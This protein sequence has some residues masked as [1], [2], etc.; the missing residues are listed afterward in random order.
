[1]NNK[2]N[3][4]V[5]IEKLRCTKEGKISK[6][7]H[8]S[9]FG[10]RM[11]NNFITT[12][13][14]EA[15][16]EIRTPICNN[17]EE[18][19]LKLE[20]I[21]N[22]VIDE[23]HKNDELLWPYSMPCIL[24]K[25]EEF[26]FG[27][28]GEYKEETKYEMDLYEKY[29]HKMH[30]M[31]G[32]H[33][34]FSL[35][36]NFFNYIKSKN[37]NLPKITDEAYLKIMRQFMEK[38]WML[39]YFFGA[40]PMQCEDDIESAISIR[41]SYKHGFKNRKLIDIDFNSRINYAKSIQKNIDAGNLLSA[42]EL[43][44]PIRAKSEN[45][46]N[47]IQDLLESEINHIEIRLCDIN[48]FDKCGI[49]KKDLEFSVAFLFYCLLSEEKK[50]LSYREVAENGITEEERMILL[51]ELNKIMKINNELELGCS[52]GIEEKIDMCKKGLTSAKQVKNMAEKKGLKEGLLE[53]A[54]EHSKDGYNNRYI[55]KNYPNLE[56]ST[57]V[58]LKSAITQGIDFNILNENK[59]F[60]ELIN[61]NHKEYIVQAT[62]TNRDSY[63]FPFITDDKY[64]AKN[65][66]KGNGLEVPESIMINNEMEEAEKEKLISRF[67]NKKCVVKPRTTNCGTG[68]TVFSE[69]ATKEQLYEAIKYAT[70]FEDD[71]LVEEYVEG[72]EYRFTVIDGK[73]ES[74]IWRRNA[75]ILGNGINTIYELIEMKNKEDW[76]LLL[77]HPIII[78]KP[79]E[80][81]IKQQGY[82][83]EYIP[84]KDE[85]IFLREN[86]NCST[87]GESVAMTEIMPEKFKKIAEQTAKL[88]NAKIC[89]VDI[90]IDNLQKDEYKII[91]INDN[92]GLSSSQWPYEGA[93]RKVGL[94]I[95]EFLSLCN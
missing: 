31:S 23:I 91:E 33:I 88:F 52:D 93:G 30:C 53:L 18:C 64:F 82:T 8:P 57:V 13:F 38:A 61:H 51:D 42:R 77:R 85:R 29:G 83:F 59:N 79:V 20:E 26:V 65:V 6:T 54:E 46:N 75:S 89:G 92:P 58:V 21:T 4:G 70:K 71:I 41:N 72:K 19:Y 60:I 17:I 34:N 7:R 63:I 5:E 32:V 45:K 39:I 44:I 12:D 43:Y 50:G 95:L 73:C 86:S 9:I 10:D 48:P 68:I 78:D 81:F 49:S 47:V 74:V 66:M 1:M 16:M 62:K 11:K 55:I 24:P 67:Y 87:G 90:L 25:A 40:T 69:K 3:I 36:K 56:A 2:F 94:R 15:Q 76:H 37:T 14:G 28:Y 27:D 84:K 22:V 80:D 35:N